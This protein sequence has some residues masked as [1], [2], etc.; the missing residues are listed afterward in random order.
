MCILRRRRI[1]RVTRFCR[2][3]FLK[4]LQSYLPVKTPVVY[5]LKHF[6]DFVK[7]K[8]VSASTIFFEFSGVNLI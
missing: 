1:R 8:V 6:Q 4:K 7:V 3:P 5:W 2:V